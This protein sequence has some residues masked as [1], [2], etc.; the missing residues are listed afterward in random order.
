MESQKLNTRRAAEKHKS[1][2]LWAKAKGMT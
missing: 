1:F 2:N